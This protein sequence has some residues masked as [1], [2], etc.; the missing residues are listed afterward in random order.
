MFGKGF[1]S[2]EDVIVYDRFEEDPRAA[3]RNIL[4]RLQHR[5]GLQYQPAL[6]PD[7]HAMLGYIPTAPV[8]FVSSGGQNY[9]TP[10]FYETQTRVASLNRLLQG[11]F[12]HETDLAWINVA[13]QDDI[14][15]F[16]HLVSD[17]GLTPIAL[18]QKALE[19]IKYETGV[20]DPDNHIDSEPLLR[21]I[22]DAKKLY[23]HN[24]CQ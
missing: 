20:G 19:L 7:N 2:R 18:D 10:W 13:I 8:L 6:V 11:N 17:L 12:I 15:Y 21:L 22:H 14:T 24:Q 1:S 23:R 9:R 4:D 5:R 3:S 16:Q